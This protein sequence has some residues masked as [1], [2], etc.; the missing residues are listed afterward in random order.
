LTPLNASGDL[1]GVVS[2]PLAA[3][4]DG[5]RVQLFDAYMTPDDCAPYQS[6]QELLGFRRY[7]GPEQRDILMLWRN[8]PE[9][10]F[11]KGHEREP[12]GIS[13]L[14]DCAPISTASTMANL[15]RSNIGRTPATT[16]SS[17]FHSKPTAGNNPTRFH[18]AALNGA[19]PNIRPTSSNR[20]ATCR[21]GHE[22][23][24]I[25]QRTDLR[26]DLLAGRR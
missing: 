20:I 11:A 25:Y 5:V 21:L 15:C 12:G 4:Y 14:A 16:T 1:R 18:A 19:M 10:F 6:D 7:Y 22:G 26:R 8:R 17:I 2:G 13:R 9:V 23:V 3:G 24:E